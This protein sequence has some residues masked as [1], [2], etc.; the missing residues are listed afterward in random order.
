MNTYHPLPAGE[1]CLLYLASDYESTAPL[2]IG[3]KPCA[4]DL[5]GYIFDGEQFTP[6][7]NDVF[8]HN[9]LVPVNKLIDHHFDGNAV[10]LIRWVPKSGFGPQENF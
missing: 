2:Y 1:N 4:F 3:R 5:A 10:W 7:V 9:G 8:S 6:V